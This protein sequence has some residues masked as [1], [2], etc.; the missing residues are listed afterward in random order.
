MFLIE[1]KLMICNST[2]EAI[3]IENDFLPESRPRGG[4]NRKS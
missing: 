2:R 4:I 1:G 3:R